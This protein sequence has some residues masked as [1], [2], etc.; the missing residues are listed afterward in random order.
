MAGILIDWFKANSMALNFEKACFIQFLTKNSCAMD[1]HIDYGNNQIAKSTTTK[2]L[3]LII[4]NMLSWKGYV[5]WLMSKLGSAC[6]A[7]RA[8]KPYMS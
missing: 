6:Y 1:M 5:E 3:G 7:M 8:V 2:F 4:N